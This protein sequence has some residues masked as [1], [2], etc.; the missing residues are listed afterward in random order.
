M[1]TVR[2]ELEA[3]YS[4]VD[5]GNSYVALGFSLDGGRSMGDD[6]VVACYGDK[7]VNYWNAKTPY[8]W[9]FPL[10]VNLTAGLLSQKRIF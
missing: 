2:F 9:S 1:D 3:K 10:E 7:V 5:D 8:I 6:A 4:G